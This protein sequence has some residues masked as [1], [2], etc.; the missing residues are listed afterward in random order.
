MNVLQ[1]KKMLNKAPKG[2]IKLGR[3]IYMRKVSQQTLEQLRS[4]G[5]NV[6]LVG[7]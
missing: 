1:R 5:I 6:I 3:F 2:T 4:L 7:G